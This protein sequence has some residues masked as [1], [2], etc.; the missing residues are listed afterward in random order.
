MSIAE[1][2]IPEPRTLPIPNVIYIPLLEL[3]LRNSDRTVSECGKRWARATDE[4]RQRIENWWERVNGR[5]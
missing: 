1:I 5:A 3:F 2:W 4:Q